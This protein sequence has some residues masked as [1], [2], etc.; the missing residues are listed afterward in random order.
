[1]NLSDAKDSQ[2]TMPRAGA[3]SD[4][5][6]ITPVLLRGLVHGH[7]ND[8]DDSDSPLSDTPD[9]LDL[10]ENFSFKLNSQPTRTTKDELQKELL[11]EDIITTAL[12]CPPKLRRQRMSDC[13]DKN[14]RLYKMYMTYNE[15]IRKAR[16]ARKQAISQ[17]QQSDVKSRPKKPNSNVA[18]KHSELQDE[19][20]AKTTL[21][22]LL[23]NR[24]SQEHVQ[25]RQRMEEPES[26]GPS[27]KRKPFKDTGGICCQPC[28]EKEQLCERFLD[29]VIGMTCLSCY[30][31]G[32]TCSL[33]TGRKLRD[34][35]AGI[36]SKAK[37]HSEPQ[38]HSKTQS[39]SKI[40]IHLRTDSHSSSHGQSRKTTAYE[41]ASRGASKTRRLPQISKPNSS[42]R[43]VNDTRAALHSSDEPENTK[44]GT[45]TTA[46]PS[47]PSNTIKVAVAAQ[48]RERVAAQNIRETLQR[49]LMRGT[50]ICD[51][52]LNSPCSCHPSQISREDILC[53]GESCSR[54]WFSNDYLEKYLGIQLSDAQ[55]FRRKYGFWSCPECSYK[56]AAQDSHGPNVFASTYPLPKYSSTY[57]EAED[58]SRSLNEFWGLTGQ[59]IHMANKNAAPPSM[60]MQPLLQ[61]PCIR[62]EASNEQYSPLIYVL[63]RI[64]KVDPG[65]LVKD[66]VLNSQLQ[67]LEC[68]AWMRAVL[69][70]L[71][72]EFVFKT[73]SPFDDVAIWRK[74]LVH[75]RC[76]ANEVETNAN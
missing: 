21:Q 55:D 63:R 75:S 47:G 1:M 49:Q 25:K 5:K 32:E 39:H 23:S 76:L 40:E 17:Q 9:T 6:Q 65:I 53:N 42:S 41:P 20:R 64:L 34:P 10:E 4:Q 3:H 56:K 27:N 59:Y 46:L 22:P 74:G 52:C 13:F 36:H 14:G 45:N 28:R 67:N 57:L 51:I 29:T 58:V 71:F 44:V 11:R 38:L 2:N 69:V 61:I 7:I 8:S 24:R 70:F 66:M 54:S 31:A 33:S 15:D 73:P 72:F 48:Q 68:S 12:D 19:Q 30:H 35:K 43:A 60:R 18:D 37:V 16:E 50:T 26:V 62:E